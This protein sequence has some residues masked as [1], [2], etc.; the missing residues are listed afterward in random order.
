VD[1]ISEGPLT[2]GTP[3]SDS[4]APVK[5]NLGAELL[6]QLLRDAVQTMGEAL[7]LWLTTSQIERDMDLYIAEDDDKQHIGDPLASIARRRLGDN[8]ASPDVA[9][10][11][12]AGIGVLAYA[13]KNVHRKITI[14]RAVRKHQAMHTANGAAS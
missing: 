10:L 5:I 1:P 14:W 6:R 3:S 11:I 9:D 2:T 12:K 8:F 7:H 4:P 13:Q